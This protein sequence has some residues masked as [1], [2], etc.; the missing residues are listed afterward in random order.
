MSLARTVALAAVLLGAACVEKD[1]GGP[2]EVKF[3][4]DTCSGCSMVISDRHFAAEVRGGPRNAVAKFDDVGCAIRW[5]S[6]QSWANEPGTRVWVA[7]HAD[8]AWVDAKTARY[9]AGKTSP[10]GFNF[11]AVDPSGEGV[12]FET[13]KEQV[14]ASRPMH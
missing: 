1:G 2:V 11:G 3:D 9:V 14:L 10:M 5:L 13:L 4:R 7:R 8:G 12:D 6:K